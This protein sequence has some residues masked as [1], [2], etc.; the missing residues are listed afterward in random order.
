MAKG[1]LN[2]KTGQL[3]LCDMHYPC[4]LDLLL[5]VNPR[6]VEIYGGSVGAFEVQPDKAELEEIDAYVMATY[7][8]IDQTM[9]IEWYKARYQWERMNPTPH[10]ALVEVEQTTPVVT[11]H[12]SL[13]S[14]GEP[15]ESTESPGELDDT[16]TMFEITRRY[17]YFGFYH[18]TLQEVGTY[19]EIYDSDNP[20]IFKNFVDEYF[21]Q[22][23]LNDHVYEIVRD[24]R[25][26][27]ET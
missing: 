5:Q 9:D 16:P 15:M 19:R 27:N 11:T 14:E 10:E 3:T 21:W 17:K 20:V 25:D 18:Y 8:F 6:W 12:G 2:K 22:L 1:I 26:C 13:K 23:E 7:E 4:L 24:E